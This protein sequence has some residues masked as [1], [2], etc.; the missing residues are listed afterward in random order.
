MNSS[1]MRMY[2]R[3]GEEV[4]QKVYLFLGRLP[5]F[6]TPTDGESNGSHQEKAG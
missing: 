3:G 4:E 2:G 1:D 5:V 6:Q